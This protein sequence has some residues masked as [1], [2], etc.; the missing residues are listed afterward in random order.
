MSEEAYLIEEIL[1]IHELTATKEMKEGRLVA[2]AV[3]VADK[4]A[5]ANLERERKVSTRIR[6]D[7]RV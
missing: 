4:V 2:L 5:R 7:Q 3:V 6:K 1:R